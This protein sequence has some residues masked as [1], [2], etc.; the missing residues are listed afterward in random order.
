MKIAGYTRISVDIE[1]DQDNTSIEN[2]KNVIRDFVFQQFPDAQLDFFEDRDRSGY[3][4]SQR[5]DYS[6]MRPKLLSGEYTILVVK[7]FSRFSRRNS[8]GLL[9]LETLRDA[10][11]R[12][13]S[14]GDAID[15]PTK[16]DWMLI[17]FKFL[18]NEF[19]VTDTSK[20]IK[21]IIANRQR[22]GRWVCAVPYGYRLIN[23]KE[24]TYEIDP[25]AAEV[26]REVFRLYNNGWG[27]RKISN[28]LTE[29][30]VPT[31]RA[32]E[33]A[34]KEAAGQTTK[35]VSK[36]A[37]SIITVQKILSNDFYIGT[38]RQHKFKRRNINGTDERV[39]DPDQIVIE[40]AHTPIIEAS[41]FAYTQGLR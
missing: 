29:K 36:N 39:D 9:E 23:T 27:Y 15:Y 4:F 35:L 41:T 28:H 17:Q 21:Q 26:V 8:L 13:I 24:M 6:R 31:P 25:P 16:D 11:V 1:K 30:G 20:K 14:V 22:D 2:Q 12:I 33:I 18:M 40:N 7:D 38:L 5:E 19:P 3:T 37:W 34:Q 10:H 32:N